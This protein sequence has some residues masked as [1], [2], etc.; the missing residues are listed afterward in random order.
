MSESGLSRLR[1][2]IVER[3]DQ[4]KAQVAH[5]LG[6]SS[7]LAADALHEAYVRLA[8]RD[9]LDQ[10]RFPQTYLINSAVNATID[11]IRKDARLVNE[12]EIGALFELVY[13]GPDPERMLVGRDLVERTIQI[14]D[15]LPPRQCALLIEHRVHGVDTADLAKRWGISRI[16]VRREIQAAHKTCLAAMQEIELEQELIDPNDP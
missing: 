11:Q 7:D 16:Q 2:L 10:V 4:L 1:Q 3:Y 6:S 13:E 14:L 9:D 5:R 15:A 8:T 12:S